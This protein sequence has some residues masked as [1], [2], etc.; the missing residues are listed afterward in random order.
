MLQQQIL[1]QVHGATNDVSSPSEKSHILIRQ[2]RPDETTRMR[3]PTTENTLPVWAPWRSAIISPVGDHTYRYIS[4]KVM[5]LLEKTY[6]DGRIVAARQNDPFSKVD[7]ANKIKVSPVETS[8]TGT[9]LHS[10]QSRWTNA[11]REERPLR[12]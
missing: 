11:W 6:L 5:W 4:Y 12:H 3:S 8:P 1:T 9:S 10:R 7:C 2:S